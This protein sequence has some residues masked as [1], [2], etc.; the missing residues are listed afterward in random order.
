MPTSCYSSRF[1]QSAD[2]RMLKEISKHSS[3]DQQQNAAPVEVE[4]T[5]CTTRERL[6]TVKFHGRCAR[7]KPLLSKDQDI[8]KNNLWTKKD[9]FIC[10]FVCTE[11]VQ[12]EISFDLK[13]NN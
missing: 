10:H 12:N 11:C 1:T 3:A 13:V 4:V 2:H 5:T 9:N 8:W 7:M 6:H